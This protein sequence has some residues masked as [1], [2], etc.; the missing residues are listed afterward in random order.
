MKVSR[1]VNLAILRFVFWVIL[2]RVFMIYFLGSL[3]KKSTFLTAKLY[4]FQ[5]I[6]SY[7]RST[8]TFSKLTSLFTFFWAC[9]LFFSNKLSPFL[10]LY[11]MYHLIFASFYVRDTYFSRHLTEVILLLISWLSSPATCL[12]SCLSLCICIEFRFRVFRIISKSYIVMSSSP[13]PRGGG[14]L[15][16][17]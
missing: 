4:E 5:K 7:F 2:I 11:L 1:H 16:V 12:M 8:S 3:Y 17:I 9:K 10:D 6:I 15:T 13:A 14:N